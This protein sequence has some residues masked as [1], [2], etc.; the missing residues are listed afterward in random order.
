[1]HWDHSWEPRPGKSCVRRRRKPINERNQE[2]RERPEMPIQICVPTVG[3]LRQE[4]H[5]L[6]SSLGFIDRASIRKREGQPRKE[7]ERK[8]ERE[9]ERERE[10]LEAPR[11]QG[12]A[13]AKKFVWLA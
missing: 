1:M 6:E 5:Q 2:Y 3:R 7:R 9:R 10:R 11:V 8:R 4:D 12:L 13:H